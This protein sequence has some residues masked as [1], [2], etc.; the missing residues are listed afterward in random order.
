MA[1]FSIIFYSKTGS[2]SME[3]PI[4]DRHFWSFFQHRFLTKNSKNSDRQHKQIFNLFFQVKK[5]RSKNCRKIRNVQTINVCE[6]GHFRSLK[7]ALKNNIFGVLKNLI[8]NKKISYIKLFTTL[9]LISHKYR[10]V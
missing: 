9:V 10:V 2:T 7:N 8:G 6:I 5:L 3:V 4:D 1:I